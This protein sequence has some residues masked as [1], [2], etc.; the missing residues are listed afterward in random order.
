[1]KQDK[2][3]RMVIPMNVQL[4]SEG[5]M[6]AIHCPSCGVGAAFGQAG[7]GHCGSGLLRDQETPMGRFGIP[8]NSVEWKVGDQY[9]KRDTLDKIVSEMEKHSEEGQYSYVIWNGLPVI[10]GGDIDAKK[11]LE[12]FQELGKQIRRDKLGKKWT[13]AL[14]EFHGL[15]VTLGTMDDELR[16]E[17]PKKYRRSLPE[18]AFLP[19]EVLSFFDEPTFKNFERFMSV[20]PPRGDDAD[21]LRFGI[22]KVR[23]LITQVSER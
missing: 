23:K 20:E 6:T 9:T 15:Q 19:S 17:L 2:E 4:K 12:N 22:N 1:M 21:F 18:D 16:T 13:R 5:G 11:S 7:C 14:E 10:V 8:N 3:A